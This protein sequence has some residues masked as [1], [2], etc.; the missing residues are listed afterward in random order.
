MILSWAEILSF[1]VDIYKKEYD[2]Y[3]SFSVTY[4]SIK[5]LKRVGWIIKNKKEAFITETHQF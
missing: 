4:D 1:L 3:K 2:V 5:M